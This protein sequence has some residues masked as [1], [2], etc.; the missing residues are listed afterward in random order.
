MGEANG[1]VIDTTMNVDTYLEFLRFALNDYG[2]VPDSV[3]NINWQANTIWQW[4]VGWLQL[5]GK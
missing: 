1:K 2:S 4:Q 5:A 3:A